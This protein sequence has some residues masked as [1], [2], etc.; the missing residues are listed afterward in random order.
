MINLKAKLPTNFMKNVH[1]KAE[2]VRTHNL[3]LFFDPILLKESRN[4]TFQPRF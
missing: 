1:R 4:L 3:L 2:K